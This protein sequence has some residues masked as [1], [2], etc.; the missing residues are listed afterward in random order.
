MAASTTWGWVVSP[1]WI[2]SSW[3]FVSET[4]VCFFLPILCYN[5]MTNIT[6]AAKEQFAQ[7]ALTI[8]HTAAM[9]GK[10]LIFSNAK[11]ANLNRMLLSM[12]TPSSPSYKRTVG[13]GITHAFIALFWGLPPIS[14]KKLHKAYLVLALWPQCC[15]CWSV[16][17]HNQ[18]H[19]RIEQRCH[20]W[21]A[22]FW[23]AIS[24]GRLQSLGGELANANVSKEMILYLENM[25][26][27]G[28][29]RSSNDLRRVQ[30][31]CKAP[32][33]MSNIKAVY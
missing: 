3:A 17:E 19:R 7:A 9:C 32:R 29:F 10:Q 8:W 5:I 22:A 21:T 12:S 25:A 2:Y 28:I 31:L 30:C 11:N 4:D 18:A 23:G 16:Q 27:Q 6:S 24:W 15:V 13:S 33:E 14:L 26:T 1:A 20:S